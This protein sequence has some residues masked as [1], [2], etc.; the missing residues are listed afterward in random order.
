M[1]Q[2]LNSFGLKRFPDII[3]KTN[4]I[5]KT[6]FIKNLEWS[7]QSFFDHRSLKSW[8]S[9]VDQIMHA[10]SQKSIRILP[11]TLFKLKL[12]TRTTR[13]KNLYIEK[14]TSC[15]WIGAVK[16]KVRST[17]Q[18]RP[19]LKIKCTNFLVVRM[20]VNGIL[21]KTKQNYVFNSVRR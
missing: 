19:G 21:V 13:Y 2:Q 17:L 7:N 11:I 8:K 4:K 5:K 3:N 15:K 10:L 6:K 20:S 9:T 14:T 16:T 1:R 12:E 18:S